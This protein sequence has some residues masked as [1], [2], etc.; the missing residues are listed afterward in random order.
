MNR[1][2]EGQPAMGGLLVGDICSFQAKGVPLMLRRLHSDAIVFAVVALV[3]LATRSHSLSQYIHLPDTSLASFFVL[4][5]LV[6]RVAAFGALFLLGFAIDVVV[7]NRFG[8]SDFCFTPA[9]WMLVPA[10]GTMWLAGRFAQNRWGARAAALPTMAAL[11]V[12]ATFLSELFSSG[13]FY[14]LGGRFADPTVAGFLPRL[15]RY[16]PPTLWATLGWSGLAAAA[17]AL[18]RVT[19]PQAHASQRP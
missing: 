16:F 17:V 12:A 3:M 19:R 4:G 10:Y 5:F 8:Q 6:R 7:I 13:G 1:A 9:Y 2:D 18:L 15:V 14:F 11:L